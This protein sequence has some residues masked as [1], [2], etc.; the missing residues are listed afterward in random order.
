MAIIL[1]TRK[2]DIDKIGL[3]GGRET[4]S[5]RPRYRELTPPCTYTCPS[6]IDIRKYLT[7]IAQSEGYKRSYEDSFNIAWEIITDKNPLP[8][9]TGR[10]CPHPCEN[11]CNRGGKDEAISINSLERF[12]GNWGIE[13]GLKHKRL[14][15]DTFPEKIAIIGG[16][17]SGLSCAYQLARRGYKITI[18]EEREKLGGMLRYGI[19]SYRLPKD[20]LDKE[21]QKILDLGIEV[22]LNTKIKDPEEI[23]GCD[24]IYIAIGAQ[25]S[26]PLNIPDE[27]RAISAISFLY[28]YNSKKPLSI[29][30]NVVVI[31][32]GNSAI[33]AARCAKRAG[34]D[35][36]ILYRRTRDEMPAISEEVDKSLEEGI[37]I[38]FLTAPIEILGD[39]LKCIRMELKGTD[40][41]GRP[42]SIPISGSE[43]TLKADTI[44]SAIGQEKEFSWDCGNRI[45]A[46]G[47]FIQIGLVTDAIGM[48]AKAAQA[49][50]EHLREKEA[51]KAFKPNVIKYTS[52]NLNYY[53]KVPR[54]L[55]ENQDG[56]IY[57]SSR[58]MS[59]GSC[60][61]CDNCYILCSDSAVKKFP[62]GQHYKFI[63]SNC[64]GCKKC[65]EECPCGYIEM[66]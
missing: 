38:E 18:F 21:I 54:G 20:I 6:G 2:R 22:R 36:K 60:F 45:F 11:E 53:E 48:A 32:G 33:D 31:G 66:I 40:E 44:I 39:G 15:N 37:K 52:M 62:K 24:V 35:V 34:C 23:R 19:P 51:Q 42:N 55:V 59:C 61:D 14:Y 10:V 43:F 29:G 13:N 3:K 28:A 8:A 64:Q 25:K 47:D 49:I 27:D 16:G 9:I 7:T 5:L 30:K 57:E 1:K 17:P 56:A 46:G 50:D 41:K 65:A 63:L 26:L 58:C 12:I 4:S